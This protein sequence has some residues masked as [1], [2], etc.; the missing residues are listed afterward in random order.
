MKNRIISGISVFII[1]LCILLTS[2]IP[3]Y[4]DQNAIKI[5]SKEDFIEFSENCTL[6]T[7][8]NEKIVDLTCNIDLENSDFSPI[9]TF[10]G[11]FNGNGYTISGINY[12]KSGSYIG[13]FRY[14]QANGKITNLN[15]KATFTP[16]GSKNFIGGIVGK[17]YGLLEHCYFEGTVKGQDV[18]GGIAGHNADNGQIISCTT[19]GNING[20]NSTGGI[21]GKNN[22][23]IQNCTNDAAVNTAYEEKKN[24]I[25]NIDMDT[26]AI[27]ENYKNNIEETEEETILGNSDTG[28]IAGYSSGI[29]QGCINNA[30]IGHQHIGYNIGGI[31]GRQSG[32]ML[33]CKNYGSIKGRKDV[34]GICGQLEPYIL[35]NVSEGGLQDIRQELN[36]LNTMVNRFITDTDNLGTDTEKHLT[37]ISEFSK[38]AR[39]NTEILLDQGADFI[40]ENVEE[41]NIQSA[42]LSNTIDKLIPVFESLG[43]SGENVETAINEVKTALDNIDI[44]APD[45][46]DEIDDIKTAL[47]DISKAQKYSDRA[48]V[49]GKNALRDLDDAVKINNASDAKNAINNLSVAIKDM[50]TAK[51]TIKTSV[52]TIENILKTNPK[53]FEEI[54]VNI[55]TITENIKTIKNSISTTIS[56]MT[57]IKKSVDTIIL[58]TEINFSEFKSATENMLTA[59]INLRKAGRTLSDGLYDLGFALK[60]TYSG[61]EDY[62]TD[63]NA[64]LQTVKIDLSKSIDSLSY[65]T[66]DITTAIRDIE[67]IVTDLSN[68][69]NLEFVKLGDDFKT[70]NNNLFNSISNISDE[71]ANLKNTVSNGKDT[72]TNNLTSISNQ[73][74]LIMNLLINEFENL[75]NGADSISDIFLDVSDEDIENT[76]QG[77]VAECHNFGNVEA[78]R[79]TGGISGAMAIE[80]TKDPEDDIEKPHT[81]NFTYRTRA[82]LQRCIND[83]KITGKKD[84]TGGIVGLSEI[85][86][87]YECQNYADIESTNGN[88]VGGIAGKSESAIRKNYAKNKLTGKRYVGGI[89][90]KANTMTACYTIVNVSGDENIGAICGYVENTDNL[91]HN[92]YVNNGLGA[93]DGIS[94]NENAMPISFDEL[95]TITSIPT[96]FISFTMTFIADDKVVE[97]QDIKYGDDTARIKYPQIPEKD[98]YFGNW[99]DIEAKTVKENIEILCE[100]KPYITVLASEE[101]NENQKLALALCEGKF[102]DK[103]ELHITNSMSKPPINADNIQTYDISLLNTDIN[104]NDLVTIRILNEN[105]DKATAWILKNGNWKK[106]KTSYK[107][108]YVILKTEGT[109]STICLKYEKRSSG[110]VLIISITIII[111][112]PTLLLLKRK[113]S[114]S[115]KS[116]LFTLKK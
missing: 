89:A 56:S 40:D 68:E 15:V 102:N 6:D 53:D 5:S 25:S 48:F 113:K 79:N 72:M 30:N 17:N 74:N 98:G 36:K 52:E 42:I 101:K 105:K 46:S 67:N 54:G 31:A 9:P 112:I 26:G 28:G 50:I 75:Q 65:A 95:Q 23:F 16:N 11:T 103:A 51:E 114:N 99:Q 94:Y 66:D 8:S 14:V 104:N 55:S 109:N 78:D 32:Y 44:Y 27:I 49:N 86:T 115:Q 13:I 77:K 61:T 3:I 19:S 35:L 63:I 21:V 2:V 73:F 82:I 93:I 92:F 76:K 18:I 34:G 84:C 22:G 96:R 45:L 58:N 7:W 100:Y 10:N 4:A 88:Y 24:D 107:G 1:I 110:M 41:I 64:E 57:T 80:Y 37:D 90:G 33:G 106:I 111:L 62:L 47:E 81:L 39:D 59:I 69:K 12:S 71:I 108:K 91:Y 87:V 60:R 20:E 97:T 116:V 38:T 43:S 29:V 70:A 85:G 83:G